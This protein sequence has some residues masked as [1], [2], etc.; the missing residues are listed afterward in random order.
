M[1]VGVNTERRKG[2]SPT[3]NISNTW[4]NGHERAKGKMTHYKC[5]HDMEIIIMDSNPLSISAYLEWSKTVGR[6]G[7]RELCWDC[8]CKNRRVDKK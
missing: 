4:K 1:G 8:W 6:D 2:R 7:T 3:T 5:G